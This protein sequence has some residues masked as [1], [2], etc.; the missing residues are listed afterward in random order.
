MI[1]VYTPGW[2]FAGHQ[3]ST[4]GNVSTDG[5]DTATKDTVA[6]PP[7]VNVTNPVNSAN[8]TTVATD[9]NVSV[10]SAHRTD[11][12]FSACHGMASQR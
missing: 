9:A 5:T 11:A 4:A 12:G 1:E 2:R 6:L 8:Q 3:G 10:D 7:S